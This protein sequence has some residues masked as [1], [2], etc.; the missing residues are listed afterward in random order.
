MGRLLLAISVG[1]RAEAGESFC[2]KNA[3]TRTDRRSVLDAI[4]QPLELRILI[5]QYSVCKNA[6]NPALCCVF[7]DKQ[8]KEK[9]E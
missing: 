9:V 6:K 3:Q 1:G 8:I 2:M 5:L 7:H 4:K